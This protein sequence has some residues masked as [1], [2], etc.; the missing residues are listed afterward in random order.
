MLMSHK[1][2]DQF[3]NPAEDMVKVIDGREIVDVLD[4]KVVHLTF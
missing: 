4:E 3:E 2:R 1:D